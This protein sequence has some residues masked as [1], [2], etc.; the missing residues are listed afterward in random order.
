M[1]EEKLLILSFLFIAGQIVVDA[2]SLQN[3]KDVLLELKIFL[4][5]NNPFNRGRYTEWSNSSSPCDWPGIS[6]SVN[7][8][9]T[10]INLSDYNI[11]G[12]MFGN[13][14]RMTELS[15][16][17]LSQNTIEGPIP[18]DLNRCKNLRHLNL[19]HNI[20]AGE[21]NLTGLTNLET[22]DLTVNRLEGGIQLNF[23]ALCNNLVTL[24]MSFNDF[25]GRIDDCFNECWKLQHLDLRDN[26]FSGPIWS[27]FQRLREFSVSENE[28]TGEISPSI[29]TEN[30]TLEL[31]DL[32][33][34]HFD[35]SIPKEV[36][37]CKNLSFLDLW[38]N[39]FT[40]TTPSEIGTLP[41]LMT[42]L[43]GK[44]RLSREI[45]ESLLNLTQLVFLDYSWNSFRGDI[46]E[47]FGKFKQLQHLVLYGNF[48]T[49]GLTTS[50]ILKLPKILRL[51]LSVNSFT[52]PLPVEFSEMPSLKYL[53]LAFNQFNG[54][55]PPEFGNF[56]AL[57]ALDLSFNRLTGKIPPTIGK[58]TSLLWLMLA[59]NSI[60]GEIPR[61]IGNCSSLLWLNLAY[62]RLSGTIPTEISNIAQNPTPTFLSNRN[63]SRVPAGSG[64][65]STMGRWI[66]TN[67]PPFHFVYSL[68]SRKSCRSIWGSLLKG[69]PIFPICST[70][71]MV[72]TLQIT[73]Y[74]QLTGNQFSGNL[75]PEIGKLHN[76]TLVHV[77]MNNLSGQLPAEIANMPLMVLEVS[78]NGFS[79]EIPSE[80]G[81][82]RCLENLDLSHNNFSGEFPAS[83]NNLTQ[84]SEFNVSLNPLI[85]GTVPPTGQL[86]TFEKESF[87]GN[88]LL[89]LP[90]F[91][92]G[93]SSNRSPPPPSSYNTK[94]TGM[95]I[96]LGFLVLTS[97]VF[98]TG[99]LLRLS[100]QP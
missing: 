48:Y 75:P 47:I 94:K 67:Y 77:G 90:N 63:S 34:N 14:S 35:G 22:L 39:N 92:N 28:L 71:S 19:S 17:D 1:S 43:L 81:K 38:D 2:S 8:R 95:Y 49:G 85:S 78:Y 54:S 29:F 30:C 93:S 88:P 5:D 16:L 52:G 86:A 96:F 41:N 15:V 97:T 73:G 64:E 18:D 21:L 46:Q 59:N 56:S 58:L 4:Q 87:L 84:L 98:A 91:M 65:C 100:L 20:L 24:N 44:N 74:L 99:V 32:S 10:G 23:P 33:E 82:A 68:L 60:T 62:N 6:C 7:E 70:G 53:I 79:G 31:L 40:G 26:N 57:Q 80:L 9:V 76:F 36:S 83:L 72:R 51:D 45:P 69:H 55:I 3:D 13:F 42:L 66:P 89:H 12:N 50:G 25:T 11:S 27:G 61:E 37:N